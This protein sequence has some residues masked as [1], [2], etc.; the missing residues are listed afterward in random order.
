MCVLGHTNR[1]SK[2]YLSGELPAPLISKY[3]CFVA[4]KREHKRIQNELL[5]AWTKR[6]KLQLTSYSW[7]EVVFVA[8][9]SNLKINHVWKTWIWWSIEEQIKIQ[10]YNGESKVW[11][12]IGWM[13]WHLEAHSKF[14]T[15]SGNL[16]KCLLRTA[17]NIWKWLY[18]VWSTS[19]N[20]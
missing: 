12:L 3:C 20:I 19:W 8:A 10:W 18:D 14:L 13:S 5:C 15:I 6:L 2:S 11:V 4:G 7:V 1:R 9:D 16:Y 17:E